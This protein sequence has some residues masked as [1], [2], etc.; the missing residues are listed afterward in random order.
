[1]PHRYDTFD[2]ESGK[3]GSRKR[4]KEFY[5]HFVGVNKLKNQ[6]FTVCKM[7]FSFMLSEKL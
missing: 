3:A 4:G 2:P 5:C 1:M 7:S 6:F